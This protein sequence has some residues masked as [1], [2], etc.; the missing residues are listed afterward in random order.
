MRKQKKSFRNILLDIYRDM[1][2][3]STPKGAFDVILANAEI[4]SDGRKIIPYNDY[5]IDEDVMKNIIN[6]HILAN[7][8]N[9]SDSKCITMHSYLGCSPKIK[10][11]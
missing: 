7:R 10:I 8:L 5:E 4:D 9:K 11:T 6:M 1:Y 2:K 3:Y